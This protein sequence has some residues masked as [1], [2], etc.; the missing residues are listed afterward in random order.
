MPVP[1][2]GGETPRALW[3]RA[4]IMVIASISGAPAESV[5]IS[6]SCNGTR[7]EATVT[8]DEAR[9]IL[10]PPEVP[11]LSPVARAVLAVLTDAPQ[12]AKA[13]ARLAGYKLNPHFR[14]GI[15]ELERHTPPLC[16]RRDGGYYR[17]VDSV[18][19]P[20]LSERPRP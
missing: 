6:V 17:P 15:R 11:G 8:P 3:I 13:L 5:E 16:A 4:A 2:P 10:G 18:D 12:T 7:V 19:V 1:C 14:G 9:A 20:P